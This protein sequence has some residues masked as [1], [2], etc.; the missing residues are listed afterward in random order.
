MAVAFLGDR[1]RDNRHLRLTE[2][3]KYGFQTVDLRVQS[4]FH[5]P[6]HARRPC[7]GRHLR[8]GIEIILL[9]KIGNL[10]LAADQVDLAISP[11]AVVLC[12]QD[13]RVDALVGAV[14]CTKT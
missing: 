6:D 11:V 14:K 8:Y 3:G 7:V 5:H 4:A 10:L 12:R 1:Q 13:V 9:L 2:C